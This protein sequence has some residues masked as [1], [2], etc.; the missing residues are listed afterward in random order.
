MA[1]KA[2]IHVV[3]DRSGSMSAIIDEAI[4]GINAFIDDTAAEKQ[5][6]WVWMF[7]GSLGTILTQK[8]VKGTEMEHF[9]RNTYKPMGM[10]PLWDA[11][12]TAIKRGRKAQRKRETKLNVLVVMTDGYENAST[13]YSSEEVRKDLETL[14]DEG[15]Q[16]IFL[17]AG[18]SAWAAASVF[19][20]VSHAF[21][22]TT[23][24]GGH[25][26]AASALRSDVAN[27]YMSSGSVTLDSAVIDDD[28][29]IV[30]GETVK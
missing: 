30:E 1:K 14:K 15:W 20:G 4:G 18:E 28:G 2:N 23:A 27:A 24:A 21:Y 16:V 8:N 6:W 9:D 7:D 19:D 17:A 5:R 26:R 22:S 29:A 11:V 13:Q 3:L 10:T 12:G 25:S